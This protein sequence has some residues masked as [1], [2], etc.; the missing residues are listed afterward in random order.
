MW[1]WFGGLTYLRTLLLF[2]VKKHLK[3]WSSKPRHGHFWIKDTGRR[4][5]LLCIDNPSLDLFHRE[6]LGILDFHHDWANQSYNDTHL[7]TFLALWNLRLLLG[8]PALGFLKKWMQRWRQLLSLL[9]LEDEHDEYSTLSPTWLALIP[10][11]M[12][13]CVDLDSFSPLN[14]FYL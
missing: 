9:S 14:S 2:F 4:N 10:S 5:N 6:T 1:W 3:H 12:T 13:S 8:L 7:S 11:K